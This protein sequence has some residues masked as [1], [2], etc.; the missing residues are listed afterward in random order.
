VVLL[1]FVLACEAVH[2]EAWIATYS[3]VARRMLRGQ[4]QPEHDA[5]A[6]RRYRQILDEIDAAQSGNVTVYSGFTPFVGVGYDHGGWSFSVNISEGAASVGGA[7]TPKPIDLTELYSYVSADIEALGIPNVTLDD[8]L[9]ADGRRVA[10]DPALLGDR[11]C[12]PVTSVSPAVVA[13]AVGQ[14][15]EHVRYYKVISVVGWGGE[16]VLSVFLRFIKLERSLFAEASYFLLPPLNDAC[17]VVDRIHRSPGW[18]EN[19]RLLWES[20]LA[21]PLL[22]A[23]APRAV[24]GSMMAPLKYERR[25]RRLRRQAA[26]TPDF[27]YGAT[28]SVREDQK[29][30]K[31]HQYFQQLDRDLYVK[32]VERQ[33]LDSLCNFLEAHDIDT[34]EMR[35][36]GSMILNSGVMMTGGVIQADN[37]AVGARAEAKGG[38]QA[39]VN[40]GTGS[41]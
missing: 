30:A 5:S 37:F 3:V 28:T 9:Y 31:Y 2:I 32:V 39:P 1:F 21:T 11:L 17:H 18:R 41:K 8:R 14:A 23:R 7:Q 35:Q 29:S 26:A 15:G 40:P 34:S 10:E 16:L 12:R 36:R 22:W 6:S 19:V 20:I 4:F 24:A 27:D 33:L 13:A 25:A 38:P